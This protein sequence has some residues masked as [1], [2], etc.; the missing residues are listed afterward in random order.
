MTAIP[1]H[2]TEMLQ[3]EL[4][5]GEKVLWA[6]QP[7]PL[8]RLK[9]QLGTC[10]FGVP[11]FAFAAFWTV[12]AHSQTKG[13]SVQAGGWPEW[14]PLLWGG[15]FM[16]FG[17]WML[18]SPLRAWWTAR[19]T[20][21]AITNKR[22]ITIEAPWKR[23]IRSFEAERLVSFE[24]REDSKGSGDIVFER[25]ASRGA[26]GGTVYRDVGFLGLPDTKEAEALLR[27][28]YER[29]KVT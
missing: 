10:V 14:F 9:S 20:V 19:H 26:K 8:L 29:T 24:R 25:E 13:R 18:L 21:Y 27:K 5:D 16:C 7:V 12:T 23:V 28:V 22:A 4:V 1:S 17:V 2:L 11:F 6:T 15:M 3:R